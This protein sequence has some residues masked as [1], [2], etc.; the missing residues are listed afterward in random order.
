MAW[1]GVGTWGPAG[2]VCGESWADVAVS[3]PSPGEIPMGGPAFSG[4]QS[5]AGKCDPPGSHP[6][7]PPGMPLVLGEDH[8]LAAGVYECE[9]V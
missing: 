4:L 6:A 7:C 9:H 5:M 3:A 2:E 8:V 1:G